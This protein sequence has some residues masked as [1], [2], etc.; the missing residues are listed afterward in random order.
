MNEKILV[1]DREPDI[2]KSLETLLKKEGYQVSSAS[3]GDEAVD[4]FK[5]EPFDLVI[6]DINMPVTS[7]LKVLRKMKKLDED[8]KLIVLTGSASIDNA[9][10]AMR[11]NGAFDFLTKPLK[12]GEQMITSVKQALEKAG[13]NGEKNALIRKP[14]NHQSAG[15]K[16]LIV[17]NDPQ[18]QKLLLAL[19]SRNG[20]QAEVAGDGFEAG[21]KVTAFKPGLIILD[22]FMP[23]MDGFE[24]C[25]RIKEDPSTSHVRVLA[26]MDHD[27][28]ENRDRIMA[29]GADSYMTKPFDRETLVNNVTS[30][31][32]S[33]VLVESVAWKT[34]T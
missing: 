11:H 2:R 25:K 4:I 10:Q 24:V 15:N 18:I 26:I 16:I 7:G 13:L 28:P 6:M 33:E 27:R 29:M 9:V 14:R 22:L 34:R 23:G 20:Y 5:S 1:V 30:L 19:L 12:N 32:K 8:I 31:L 21:V 17:D 3:G